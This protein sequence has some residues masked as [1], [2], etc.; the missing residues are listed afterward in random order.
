[1]MRLTIVA[2]AV[3]LAGC[4]PEPKGDSYFP[5]SVGSSWTYDLTSDIDGAITHE[6]QVSIVP[7]TIDYEGG[8]QVIVRRAEMVGGI[9]VEYWLR[10]DKVGIARIAQR[11]DL[12]EIAKLD[13]NARTVLKLPLTIGGSWMVPTQ[14]FVIGPKTDLG[15]RDLKMPK[16]LMTNVVEAMDDVVTVPAGTFKECARVV[17]NGILPLYLDAVQGF[18][19]IPIINR[20]WY[21]KG[22]G[23][24]KVERVEELSSNFFS[25]GKI[26]MELSDFELR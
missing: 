21:C 23:L 19:D 10:R 9:G 7:R 17:G 4:S 3:L 6:T 1:M 8:D 11:T 16:V 25:G 24:V 18:K 20:E 5:L 12:D 14:T 26:T 15:Q 2:A 13:P 22:V